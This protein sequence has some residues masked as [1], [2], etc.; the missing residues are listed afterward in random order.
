MWTGKTFDMSSSSQN[1]LRQVPG[2]DMGPFHDPHHATT[3]DEYD[4]DEDDYDEEDEG[5]DVEQEFGESH[6]ADFNR[7]LG[8]VVIIIFFPEYHHSYTEIN[9]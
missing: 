3:I 1:N 8:W 7:N 4:P 9:S 6:G 2:H 5:E